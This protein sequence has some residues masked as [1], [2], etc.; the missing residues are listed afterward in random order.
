M[1]FELYTNAPLH[2]SPGI[3]HLQCLSHRPSCH[4]WR[5]GH[6]AN[7]VDKASDFL[8]GTPPPSRNCLVQEPPPGSPALLRHNFFPPQNWVLYACGG[9]RAAIQ[10]CRT[11]FRVCCMA[12]HAFGIQIE[13]H[14]TEFE[15][16]A[17]THLLLYHLFHSI[18]S[19][20]WRMF[21]MTS[22]FPRG[23]SWMTPQAV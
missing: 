22:F 12:I 7:L 2:L 14:G 4:G 10:V 13:A 20:A 8:L 16:F 6:T 3:C 5:T 11:T 18:V 21:S 19:G 17:R 23:T 1:L 15:V 9:C